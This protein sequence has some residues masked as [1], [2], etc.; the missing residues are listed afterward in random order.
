MV[1][2]L[3]YPRYEKKLASLLTNIKVPESARLLEASGVVLVDKD[4]IVVFDEMYGIARIPQCSENGFKQGEIIGSQ[5][6]R[7]GF[8]AIAFD[9]NENCFYG[10]VENSAYQ[11]DCYR[12][13][14]QKFTRDL[15]PSGNPYQLP[16]NL[17]LDNIDPNKGLEGAAIVH[18]ENSTFIF[19]LCEGK[20]CNSDDSK[21]SSGQG[22]IQIFEKNGNNWEHY[23][24]LQLPLEVDFR[25]FSDLSIQQNR[26]AVI[27]QKSA[28]L[29][30]GTL[31]VERDSWQ[32]SHKNIYSFPTKKGKNIYCNIE[33]VDWISE[34]Q[35]VIVSDIASKN[36]CKAKEKMIHVF[37]IPQ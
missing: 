34:N 4:Y 36:R 7:E 6:S 5:N 31:N 8:E 27:S 25:D 29:W 1:K 37:D 16:L 11:N 10:I 2:T 32:L 19:G 30:I 24:T 26:I 17:P 23:G 21:K 15:V 18:K 35:L 3:N 13:L 28:R 14:I 33:G 22:M 9:S 20:N 12:P